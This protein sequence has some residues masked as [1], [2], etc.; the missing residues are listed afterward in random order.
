MSKS[1]RNR[2]RASEKIAQ[3]RMRE[4]RRR[5][6]KRLLIAAGAAVVVVAATVGIT[7]A[8]TSGS[9]ASVPSK[10]AG[11][12]S[13]APLSTLG[14]LR[15][16]PSAG[17]LGPEGVPVPS[18]AP[19]S[20]A[21]HPRQ[22]PGDPRDQLPDQRADAVPHPRPPDGVRE[23][24]GPPDP[25]QHRDPRRPRAEHAAGQLRRQRQL[26]LLAAHPLRRRH[27][28][29]RVAGQAHLHAGRLLRRVGPAARAP[30][31]AQ[32]GGHVTAIYN[33]H[34][35]RGDPASIPLTAHAQIQLEIGKPLLSP[36]SITFPKGL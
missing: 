1:A 2:Q 5:R 29:H 15:P 9:P 12:L 11:S 14:A 34:V 22:R 4:A 3:M 26:L 17:P 19:L 20:G 8:A 18:A 35:Y 16:A 13:L 30:P 27:H 31:A 21:R 24:R 25:G 28:P 6:N 32:A 10:G 36:T 23:W 7:L 33:G